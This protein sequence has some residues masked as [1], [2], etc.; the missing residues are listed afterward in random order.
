MTDLS[1]Y[2]DE[3][4]DLGLNN[5][6][7]RF[8]ILGYLFMPTRHTRY[9][10]QQVKRLLYNINSRIKQ[11]RNRLSEFKFSTNKK[12]TRIRVLHSISQLNMDLGIV[13]I[14]K[15][16]VRTY[17]E[18]DP[19][20][21][22]NQTIVKNVLIPLADK[23]AKD[24]SNNLKIIMDKSMYDSQILIFNEYCKERIL[25]RIR[26]TNPRKNIDVIIA[27]EDSQRIPLLQIADY[28]AGVTQRKIR[29]GDPKYYD[30]ISDR[31]IHQKTIG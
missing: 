30:I 20:T 16:A 24:R 19:R 10:T 8:F 12:T 3:A 5:K 2:V 22:Y 17:L 31:I 25:S 28:V 29:Y 4:G 14:N 11:H 15:D 13:C 27:H 21:F 18:H 9:K 6:S 7:S 26:D 23:Y 1:I